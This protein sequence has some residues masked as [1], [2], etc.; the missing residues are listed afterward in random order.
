M[1]GKDIATKNAVLSPEHITELH[2][3]F[4]LYVDP[5]QRR[6]DV[7]ELL[8]TAS[9]LGLDTKYELVF[10][11]LADI[12]DSTHGAPLDFEGFLKEVTARLVQ[13]SLLREA[14]SV[15]KE[16]DRTST[17]WT[18]RPRENS[19]STISDTLASSSSTATTMRLSLR[20]STASAAMALRP[21]PGTDSTDSSRRRSTKEN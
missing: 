15:K 2:A 8:S 7:R 13:I 11:L 14:P 18:F 5:R 17:F 20:S 3:L 9:T 6:A 4:S 12:N 16:E 19:I 1:L 10:R 21:S